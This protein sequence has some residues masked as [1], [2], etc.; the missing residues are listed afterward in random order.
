MRSQLLFLIGTIHWF[1]ITLIHPILVD[2]A[3]VSIVPR[4]RTTAASSA[5][6]IIVA[7]DD[8]AKDHPAE[9]G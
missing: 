6:D 2:G 1:G 3:I 5:P 9:V 8:T 4:S 7:S